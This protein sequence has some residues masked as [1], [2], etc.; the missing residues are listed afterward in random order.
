[1]CRFL[2]T[3]VG[4]KNEGVGGVGLTRGEKKDPSWAC[5]TGNRGHP[6][7][8]RSSVEGG[9]PVATGAGRK[10]RGSGARR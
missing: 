7:D 3:P 1:M 2:G 8:D 9:M 4:R 5:S 10:L 6:A